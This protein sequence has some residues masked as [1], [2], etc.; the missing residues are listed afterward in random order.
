MPRSLR[1][2]QA[3]L[4]QELREIVVYANDMSEGTGA[5][6][7]TYK[8]NSPVWQMD[9][10]A[11]SDIYG[12]VKIPIDR[13]PGTP[14]DVK[15]VFATGSGGG[16]GH[17]LFNLPYSIAGYGESLAGANLTPSTLESAAAAN[18]SKTSS[19][20]RIH[21]SRMDGR[22][23]SVDI[24]FRVQ[25]EGAHVL[26]THNHNIFFVKAIFEYTAYV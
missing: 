1:H 15:I 24:G 13:V 10:D 25:R 17:V 12:D 14:I 8:G 16:H 18:L 26:D 22:R 2:T 11:I 20:L 23:S 3:L 21:E 6:T 7:L 5:P 4:R 19:P 9:D